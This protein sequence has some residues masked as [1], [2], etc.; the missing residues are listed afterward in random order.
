MDRNFNFHPSNS[1]IKPATVLSF[2]LFPFLLC[3]TITHDGNAAEPPSFDFIALLQKT[4]DLESLFL[5]PGYTTQMASSY[6]RSGGDRD[7]RGY[8]RKEA[9][10]YIIAEMQ[11][12]GAITRIGCAAPT[13]LI[14]FYID[15]GSAPKIQVD[16]RDLF[17]GKIKPFTPPFVHASDSRSGEHWSYI[18]IPYAHF[19][20]VAVQD[21]AYYQIEFITFPSETKIVPFEYPISSKNGKRLA[22]LEKSFRVSEDTPFKLG[23][24]ME[25]YSIAHSLAAGERILLTT[26]EGPAVVRGIRMQWRS[27]KEEEER[28]L[29]LRC[30]W[31]DEKEPS[32]A[33]PLYDFFGGGVQ[34]LALGKDSSRWSYCYFPMP[35]EKTA[36]LEIENSSDRDSYDLD[37]LLDVQRK[38]KLPSNLRRFHAYWRRD[39]DTAVHN[40]QWNPDQEELIS[41]GD[42]NFIALSAKGPG[43]L[44]GWGLQSTPFPE[45]DAMILT[46]PFTNTP[47]FP[48]TGNYG[49]FD[50]AGEFLSANGPISGSFKNEDGKNYI[51][52]SF[53]PGVI[54]FEKDIHV[55]LEH[56]SGNALRKDYAST[57]YG[58][59]ENQKSN[60]T[61]ILPPGVRRFRTFD[62]A[63]PLIE[64]DE[65]S[66]TLVLPYEAESLPIEA[67]LG[68]YDPQDM[69]SYGPNW[70]GNQQIRFEAFQAGGSMS[71]DLPRLNYSGWRRLRCRLTSEPDGAI[72]SIQA[73]NDQILRRMDLSSK[74]RTP[75]IIDAERP[76]FLHA[77]DE[78]HIRF[79]VL[80]RSSESEGFVVG[81]DTL[82]WLDYEQTPKSLE[83]VGPFGLS[84]DPQRTAPYTIQTEDGD[85]ILLGFKP[86][87]APVAAPTILSPDKGKGHFDLGALLSAQNMEKGS[88]FLTWSITA[89]IDGIYRF[90]LYPMEISPFL[91][92]EESGSMIP[93]ANHLLINNIPLSGKDVF[94]YD[95]VE[96]RTLP[97]R[98]RIPLQAGINRLSWLIQCNAKTRIRPILYGLYPENGKK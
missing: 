80:D 33:V 48:G 45:S 47:A 24:E 95:P 16:F 58:Y 59:L 39:N 76:I 54:E 43:H 74:K 21:L 34:T 49:F 64:I 70:S 61:P 68:I 17:T 88:C 7:N 32:V 41:K 25:E 56:G 52:R 31:D 98:Y 44:V 51:F 63:Q 53:L 90:E 13:G 10:W 35:F 42:D 15:Q 6:D 2:F 3:I 57:L 11:G 85:R 36:Y 46:S 9:E 50:L 86:P 73:N 66:Q 91:Y 22:A 23:G 82:E 37:I 96:K 30:Y 78:P 72:I 18:P 71:F 1:Q 81:V 28:D 92:R 79:N 4:L 20:K 89:E 29:I 87:D 12:P 67:V 14:R 75:K 38:V 69:L 40:L 55:T 26:M 19:C 60:F 84:G 8:L 77:A 83:L 5:P 65:E 62:L 94:R 93:L 27:G 97:L